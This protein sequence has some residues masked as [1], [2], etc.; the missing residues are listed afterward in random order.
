MEE[1]MKTWRSLAA[2]QKEKTRLFLKRL[3]PKDE[4]KIDALVNDLHDRAFERIDCLQCANC[5]K[6]LSP[7]VKT[8]DIE[9]I[10]SHL[11]LKQSDFINRYVKIDEDG[12]YVFNSTPCPFLAEDNYCSIYDVR[13]RDCRDYPHTQKQGFVRRLHVNAE[14]TVS[15]PAVFHIVEELKKVGSF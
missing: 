14:N 12:D 9:R 1:I 3:K 6:T 8:P 11:R 5:C 13:P 7:I 15:C 2:K 4:K 10:A